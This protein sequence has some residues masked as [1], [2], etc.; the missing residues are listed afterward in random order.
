MQEN[1][2][3][4]PAHAGPPSEPLEEIS[5]PKH[6]FPVTLQATTKFRECLIW[7]DA[8]TRIQRHSK[9]QN[10]GLLMTWVKPSLALEGVI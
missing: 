1:Q 10:W 3:L 4:S 8:H 5:H 9:D 2:L 7:L 6:Q